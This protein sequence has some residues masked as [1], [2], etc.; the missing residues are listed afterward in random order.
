MT[1]AELEKAYG[2]DSDIAKALDVSRQLV[3]HWRKNGTI[4]PARQAW[5]ELRSGGRF[6]AS[7]G[8]REKRKVA[9]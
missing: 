8:T 6:K 1:L 9:A 7:V 2:S 3:A 4:A 5:I